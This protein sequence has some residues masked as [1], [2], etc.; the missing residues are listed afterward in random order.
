MADVITLAA[1]MSIKVCGGPDVPFQFGRIDAVGP[2]PPGMLPGAHIKPDELKKMFMGRLGLSIEETVAII[3]GGHSAGRS[4]RSDNPD[5]A[6]VQ[7]GPLDS[8]PDLLDNA[9]FKEILQRPQDALIPAD[10]D[11]VSDP[12]LRAVIERFAGKEDFMP[13]FISAMEKMAARGQPKF[14]KK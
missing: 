10:G 6:T 3:G 2:N 13:Y 8:T 14:Q 7:T 11:M 1:Y 9:F 12:E 4:R 5:D